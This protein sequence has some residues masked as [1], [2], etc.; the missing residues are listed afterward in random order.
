MSDIIV[1]LR[2]FGVTGATETPDTFALH[3]VQKVKRMVKILHVNPFTGVFQHKTS[4]ILPATTDGAR[5]IIPAS[6]SPPRKKIIGIYI[7]LERGPCNK[8]IYQLWAI[9]ENGGYGFWDL[10]ETAPMFQQQGLCSKNDGISSDQ[11]CSQV[12]HTGSIVVSA[13]IQDE[14]LKYT[15]MTRYDNIVQASGS[16]D[17][18]EYRL[19]K[20][21]SHKSNVLSHS[22]FV[23]VEGTQ[24]LLMTEMFRGFT[25]LEYNVSGESHKTYFHRDDLEKQGFD[26]LW[27]RAL[28]KRK[29]FDS[30]ETQ[31]ERDMEYLS[32]MF[33]KQQLVESKKLFSKEFVRR[34]ADNLMD[35]Y[36]SNS[37]M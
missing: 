7:L 37:E 16:K 11:T 18:F 36:G 14:N 22:P 21:F 2:C 12:D 28:E 32:R 10:M 26:C 20:I 23:N 34:F 27:K 13:R 4:L 9:L 8:W 35:V 3:L 19:G 1:D 29:K 31:G 33:R 17:D 15:C 30:G 24:R 6:L 25:I 5:N